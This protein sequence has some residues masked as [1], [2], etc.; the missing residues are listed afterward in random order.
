M[1]TH[2]TTYTDSTSTSSFLN[3]PTSSVVFT[4]DSHNDLNFKSSENKDGGISVRLYFKFLKS[5]LSK[6]NKEKLKSR[7]S[8]L[9]PL[10]KYSKEVGQSALYERS[11]EEVIKITK[12]QELNILGIEQFI[13]EDI[14]EKYLEK[15]KDKDNI[16][17][18]ELSEY[19]RIIPSKIVRKLKKLKDN[20]AFSSYH[21]L[22]TDYTEEIMESTK[23]KIIEKDPIIF[24]KCK[25]TNDRLFFIADWEDEYC[26][27]VFDKFI[28]KSHDL[29]EKFYVGK[30]EPLSEKYI[31]N[32]K[33]ELKEKQDKLHNTNY[34]NYKSLAESENAKEGNSLIK[35][36]I[37]KIKKLF[38]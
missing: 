20:N 26:N 25:C 9:V 37:V 11:C 22:Y 6:T 2:I 21:I 34:R 10:I 14:I 28:S 7:L 1:E 19:P 16:K 27:L 31:N 23:M 4:S 33:Q 30:L 36:L 24:G 32:I 15:V 13:E 8:H 5:K 12:E 35:R 3:T 18:E 38:K 17:F 29:D